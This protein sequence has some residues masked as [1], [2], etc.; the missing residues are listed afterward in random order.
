MTDSIAVA[1]TPG[2]S[3]DYDAFERCGDDAGVEA[4]TPPDVRLAPIDP[5]N[6]FP[7]PS[8]VGERYKIILPDCRFLNDLH[9]EG[10][11]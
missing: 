11:G 4:S 8:A 1:R 3:H 7:R 9:R 5:S 10:P 2:V 6:D